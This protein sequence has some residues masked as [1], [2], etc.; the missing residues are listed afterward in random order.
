MFDFFLSLIWFFFCRLLQGT[1]TFLLLEPNEIWMED[2]MPETIH[3]RIFSEH[4][5]AA[6]VTADCDR[7]ARRTV[8]QTNVWPPDVVLQKHVRLDTL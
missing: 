5:L 7:F 1:Q 4:D 6:F 2:L 3:F 8:S